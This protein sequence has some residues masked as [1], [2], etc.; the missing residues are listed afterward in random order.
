M[1]ELSRTII[2]L[3]LRLRKMQMQEEAQEAAQ[4][5]AGAEMLRIINIR[6]AEHNREKEAAEAFQRRQ[7]QEERRRAA[8]KERNR[9]RAENWEKYT[10]RTFSCVAIAAVAY[11]L[12]GV[13]AV[14]FP[15]ALIV[16]ILCGVFCIVNYAAYMT[17]NRK[18]GN[19]KAVQAC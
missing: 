17:R 11:I 15:L 9:R 3:K 2:Q 7:R 13:G 18:S 16:M 19:R 12:D 8:R 4:E 6:S 1:C 5:A 14:A 10:G